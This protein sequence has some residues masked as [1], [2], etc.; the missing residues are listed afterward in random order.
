MA[1]IMK[2]RTPFGII[3]GLF[4]RKDVSRGIDRGMRLLIYGKKAPIHMRTKTTAAPNT[5][6]G[7]FKRSKKYCECD[8]NWKYLDATRISRIVA[9]WTWATGRVRHPLPAY[10][11]WM[12]L[13]L[14]NRAEANLYSAYCWIGRYRYANTT[15]AILEE[16]SI[17]LGSIPWSTPETSGREVW[18]IDPKGY[19]KRDT[20]AVPHIIIEPGIIEIT[21]DTMGPDEIKR[22]DVYAYT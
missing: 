10:H 1:K 22:W 4:G 16:H 9:A 14:Q 21:V 8:E 13:C 17:R 19:I 11:I 20:E 18:A 2:F 6:P 15:G 5:T 12:K 7:W 3:S